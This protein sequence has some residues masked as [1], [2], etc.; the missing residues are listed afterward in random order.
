MSS[1]WFNP[2]ADL[3]SQSKI[4]PKCGQDN[5]RY[6]LPVYPFNKSTKVLN[7][8]T[9]CLATVDNITSVDRELP[10]ADHV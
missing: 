3:S 10:Q 1:M 6:G 2:N 8:C 5:D 7:W 4:C 9:K